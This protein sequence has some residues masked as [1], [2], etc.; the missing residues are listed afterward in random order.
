[1]S[2]AQTCDT[3]TFPVILDS[4]RVE[5]NGYY[6]IFPEVSMIWKG[7]ACGTTQH[8]RCNSDHWLYSL[9]AGGLVTDRD[10]IATPELFIHSTHIRMDE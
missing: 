3:R 4:N 5:S 6:R 9:I 7:E 10:S 8:L 2:N 1:M